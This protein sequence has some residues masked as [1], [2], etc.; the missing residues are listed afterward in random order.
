[1]AHAEQIRFRRHRTHA[2]LC[3]AR[4][5][6][7]YYRDAADLMGTVESALKESF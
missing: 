6:V 5:L 2:P 1:M 4:Q 7:R 3:A